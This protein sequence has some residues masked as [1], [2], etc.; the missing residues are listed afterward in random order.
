MQTNSLQSCSEQVLCIPANLCLMDDVEAD[1]QLIKDLVDSKGNGVVS[2]VAKAIGVPPST[3]NRHYNGSARHR[4]SRP[5]MDKLRKRYPD[6]HGWLTFGAKVRSEVSGFEDRPFGDQANDTP[7]PAIPLV[8]SAMGVK[9]FDPE[10]DVELT[11]L[12]MSDVLD[13]VARPPSLARDGQAYALTVIGDS[14]W[15]RFRAGQRIIVSPRAAVAIGDDVIVQLKG[16]GEEQ[17]ADRVTMVLI[18]ELVR[19]TATYIELRQ[20]NP[21]VTFRVDAERV[22]KIHKVAGPAY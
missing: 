7:L 8:G 22:A 14:M 6:F 3:I 18:K 10:R 11:E 17:L 4:V 1:H 20:F 15:P 2:R 16:T 21:D 12:E 9:S 13:H 5:I 19:R